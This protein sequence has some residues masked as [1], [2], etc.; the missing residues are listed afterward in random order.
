MSE[1]QGFYDHPDWPRR[2]LILA[3]GASDEETARNYAAFYLSPELAAGRAIAKTLPPQLSGP[4][5]LVAVSDELRSHAEAI[6]RGDLSRPEAMLTGQA[7]ALESLWVRLLERAMEQKHAEHHDQLMRLALKAQA[8][9]VRTLEVLAAIKQPPVVFATQANVTTGP[10]QV[11]NAPPRARKVRTRPTQLSRGS[12]E[13]LQNNRAARAAVPAD[14]PLEA[15]GEVHR[16]AHR[17]R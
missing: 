7:Q 10:Q 1:P 2:S 12:D 17:R 5:D 6:N 14:P 15:V 4:I 16:P 3:K 8:Q 9:S 11:N 13:L